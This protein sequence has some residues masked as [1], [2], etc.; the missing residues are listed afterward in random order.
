MVALSTIVEHCIIFVSK[1]SKW[2]LDAWNCTEVW[3][4]VG[5]EGT[6][7]LKDTSVANRSGLEKILTCSTIVER[8]TTAV[9]NA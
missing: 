1:L 5:G 6:L 4:R 9:L 2:Q 3:G 8:A 7:T